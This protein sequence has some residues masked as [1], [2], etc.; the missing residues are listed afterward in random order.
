MVDGRYKVMT[1][2]DVKSYKEWAKKAVQQLHEA[3]PD[4][5]FLTESSAVPFGWSLKNAWKERYPDEDLPKFYRTSITH[6][7]DFNPEDY[8]SDFFNFFNK[9]A[10]DKNKRV[11]IFDEYDKDNNDSNGPVY[12]VKDGLEDTAKSKNRTLEK[13]VRAFKKA[14]FKN[15]LTFS[16]GY[17]LSKNAYGGRQSLDWIQERDK[18]NGKEYYIKP[19]GKNY[20]NPHLGGKIEKNPVLRKRALAYIHDLKLIGKEAGLEAREAQQRRKNLEQH[21]TIVI[22]LGGFISG[23]FFIF[24]NITGNAIAN[25]NQTS[26]KWIGATLFIIGL[27]GVFFYFKARR[28]TT[29]AK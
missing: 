14:G 22:S 17:G 11:L 25:L 9:R 23:L 28:K 27:A 20:D 10:P 2:E 3:K 5:I 18:E 21:F 13:N 4:C 8:F 26:I 7:V 29:R 1:S 19:T 15:I 12:R 6:G 24:S 16:G